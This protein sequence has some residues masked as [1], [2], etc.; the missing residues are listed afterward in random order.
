[1]NSFDHQNLTRFKIWSD[2]IVGI[3]LHRWTCLSPSTSSFSEYSL[4]SPSFDVL[5]WNFEF[6]ADLSYRNFLLNKHLHSFSFLFHS[7]SFIRTSFILFIL[8]FRLFFKRIFFVISKLLSAWGILIRVIILITAFLILIWVK[9]N[10]FFYD[11]YSKQLTSFFINVFEQVT[12][13]SFFIGLFTTGS[14][15]KSGSSG[16]YSSERVL[17]R[18]ETPLGCA[19]I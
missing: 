6:S 7:I 18:F 3:L 1:M 15:F 10:L 8:V 12:L 17:T 2:P 9:D 14:A 4:S 16:V 5:T 13:F 19:Q 11:L